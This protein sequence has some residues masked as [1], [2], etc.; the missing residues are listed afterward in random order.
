MGFFFQLLFVGFKI[1]Y[2]KITKYQ[3]KK[4]KKANPS[5]LPLQLYPNH[6]NRGKMKTTTKRKKSG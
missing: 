5:I 6:F 1:I 2:P 3:L 4:K